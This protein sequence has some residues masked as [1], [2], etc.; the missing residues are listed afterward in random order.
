MDELIFKTETFEGPLELLEN[1]IKKNKLDILEKVE[2]MKRH[3]KLLLEDKCENVASY[4]YE[5]CD[6]D[7]C[8]CG[9]DEEYEMSVF[10]ENPMLAQSY[11]P[12]QYMDKTFK[13][14]ANI[15]PEDFIKYNYKCICININTSCNTCL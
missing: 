15:T 4:N 7:E 5:E 11:V 3:Y 12:W 6:K 1:L 10:P 9:F 14:E 2:M 8:E 13:P